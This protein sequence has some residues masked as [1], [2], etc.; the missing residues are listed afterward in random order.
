MRATTPLTAFPLTIVVAVVAMAADLMPTLTNLLSI[1]LADPQRIELHQILGCHLLHWSAEH[2]FWDLIM[3]CILGGCCERW[4]PKQYYL[5][6][7]TSAL[8]IPLLIMIL[9]PNISSY[10]GLSGI[11]TA[12]FSLM[13]VKVC[14]ASLRRRDWSQAVLF[15]TLLTSLI[16]K[17]AYEFMTGDLLFVSELNFVPLPLA[18]LAGGIVGALVPLACRGLRAR[19]DSG[20][21]DGVL[22]SH[23]SIPCRHPE[24]SCEHV[25]KEFSWFSERLAAGTAGA[26][27]RRPRG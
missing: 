4:W 21:N 20:K 6:I 11:D 15:A 7:V 17:V 24:L 9:Q 1:N 23:E 5:T 16:G 18:H 14:A 19:E 8:V 10:R 26:G 13:A 3:F 22:R 25:S 2:L 12:I 27:H